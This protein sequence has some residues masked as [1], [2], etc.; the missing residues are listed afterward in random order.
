MMMMIER[1]FSS[2]GF[3]TWFDFKNLKVLQEDHKPGNMFPNQA[4]P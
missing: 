2:L 4:G 3:V 1:S